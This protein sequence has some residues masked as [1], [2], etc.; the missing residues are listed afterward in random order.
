M[1]PELLSNPK[2]TSLKKIKIGVVRGGLSAERRISLR[3]GRAVTRALK[4][5]GVSA[6]PID[7]ADP[8]TFSRK[9]F[10]RR[11]FSR[12]TE[13]FLNWSFSKSAARSFIGGSQ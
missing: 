6:F 7:P 11:V 1:Q 8:K 9:I 12:S 5:V 13:Y 2:F 10:H 4:R 3:S